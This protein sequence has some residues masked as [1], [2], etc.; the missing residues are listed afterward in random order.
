LAQLWQG[1]VQPVAQLSFGISALAVLGAF[2]V[3]RRHI[4]MEK[5]E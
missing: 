4:K 2:L 3:A 1:F 5:V